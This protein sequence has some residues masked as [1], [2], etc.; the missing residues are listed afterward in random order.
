ME[1]LDLTDVTD[2]EKKAI[3]DIL[4]SSKACIAVEVRSF[5]LPD[6]ACILQLNPKISYN[7]EL[8]SCHSNRRYHLNHHRANEMTNMLLSM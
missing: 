6:Y 5:C 2:S 7:F 4:S 3:Q 8:F 1:F